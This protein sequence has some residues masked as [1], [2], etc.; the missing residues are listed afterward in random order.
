VLDKWLPQGAAADEALQPLE[1]LDIN[2]LEQLAR[3]TSAE[4][5]PRMLE[6]FRT[7]ATSRVQTIAQ[8]LSPAALEQLQREAHSLKS[9]AGTFG[10][11]ELQQLAHKLELACRNDQPGDI[12]ETARSIIEAWEQVNIELENYQTVDA[13]EKKAAS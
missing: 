2:T 3:D 5:L 12:E 10:A 4:M 8:H 7:E 6:A 13:A 9:S 11:L 1:V